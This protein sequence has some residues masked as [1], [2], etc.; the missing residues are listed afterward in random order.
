MP[1][2]S[3]LRSDSPLNF[4]FLERPYAGALKL[5]CEAGLTSACGIPIS[6][7]A[8]NWW[9]SS[10]LLV[11]CAFDTQHCSRT[12]NLHYHSVENRIY[13]GSCTELCWYECAPSASE[14]VCGLTQARASVRAFRLYIDEQLAHPV[15]HR[16]TNLRSNTELDSRELLAALLPLNQRYVWLLRSTCCPRREPN[17]R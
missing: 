13:P 17:R 4:T 16:R 11:D 7:M 15:E 9:F 3:D 8:C 2:F 12:N 5:S 1:P 10:R 14:S 6:L